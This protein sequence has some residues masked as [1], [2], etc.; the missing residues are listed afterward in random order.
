MLSSLKIN[1]QV[2]HPKLPVYSSGYIQ[3]K[4]SPTL[5]PTLPKIELNQQRSLAGRV[6][7]A[8]I[9]LLSSI[10]VIS[11][12]FVFVLKIIHS[13]SNCNSRR[14]TP[15][16]LNDPISI[17]SLPAFLRGVHLRPKYS[18]GNASYIKKNPMKASLSH[19][20]DVQLKQLIDFRNAAHSGNWGAIRSAHFDWFMFPIEE[21]SKPEYCAF[22]DDV[23]ELK[24]DN[25]WHARYRESIQLV[26][27]AWGWDAIKGQPS[28]SRGARWD[29]WDIRLAKIIRSTW[30]FEE[31]DLMEGMQ[32]L[33]CH[34]KPKGGLHYN[35]INLD[36]VYLMKL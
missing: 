10:P 29:S 7:Q 18:V 15:I 5:I 19:M 34:V 35:G 24:S 12:I 33:A 23:K 27:N 30:L 14:H 31:K 1:S 11:S 3:A 26:A 13:V 20:K 32:A 25:E 28:A 36:E 8:V 17:S 2:A 9:S 21:G 6:K 4:A 16:Q 22:E